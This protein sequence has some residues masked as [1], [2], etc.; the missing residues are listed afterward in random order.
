[1][2]GKIDPRIPKKID[3]GIEPISVTAMSWLQQ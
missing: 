1:M 3:T 2:S